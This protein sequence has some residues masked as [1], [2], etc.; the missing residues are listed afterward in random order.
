MAALSEINCHAT[1]LGDCVEAVSAL[2]GID[3][4]TRRRPVVAALTGSGRRGAAASGTDILSIAAA[5]RARQDRNT[6]I[7]RTSRGRGRG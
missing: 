2:D 7:G 1:R 5:R 3:V 6:L 4:T